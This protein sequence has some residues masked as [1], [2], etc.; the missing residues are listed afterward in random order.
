ML[1]K[2][3]AHPAQGKMGGGTGKGT[4][5]FWL[6]FI[7]ICSGFSDKAVGVLSCEPGQASSPRSSDLLGE[8]DDKTYHPHLWGSAEQ[9]HTYINKFQ[10]LLENKVGSK[11]STVINTATSSRKNKV[12][13]LKKSSCPVTPVDQGLKV[14]EWDA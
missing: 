2:I 9:P 6:V 4:E 11:Q 12:F 14:E 5:S 13:P 8:S 7:L 1:A 10:A 3:Q